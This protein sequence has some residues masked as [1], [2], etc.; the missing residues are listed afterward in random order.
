MSLLHDARLILEPDAGNHSPSV[1]D[2][3]LSTRITFVGV[4]CKKRSCPIFLAARVVLARLNWEKASSSSTS[5]SSP[6][7]KTLVSFTKESSNV[8]S[9]LLEMLDET[10]ISRQVICVR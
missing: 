8:S 5:P 3:S 4:T 2:D 7:V 9:C 1:T 10:R 6:N